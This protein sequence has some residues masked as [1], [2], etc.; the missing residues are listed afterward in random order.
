MQMQIEQAALDAASAGPHPPPADRLRAAAEYVIDRTRPDQ[1]ILF[2]SAARGEFDDRSDFDFAIVRAGASSG[3]SGIKHENWYCE[4][5]D[6]EIDALFIDLEQLEARRWT[7]GTVHCAILS[8]GLT[9]SPAAPPRRIDTLRDGGAEPADIRRLVEQG[10]YDTA[11][12]RELTERAREYL[13]S[14]I[15]IWNAAT[16]VQARF[17][18]IACE[19][20]GKAAL[21]AL[22]GLI[23][24][25][26]SPAVHGRDL[27]TLWMRAEEIGGMIN[28]QRNNRGLDEL[29]RYARETRESIGDAREA[30]AIFREARGT[31]E[32]LVQHA[33]KTAAA[34][35]G[36]DRR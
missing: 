16:P 6:A 30:G 15:T 25:N 11:W 28:G 27:T 22:K 12:A 13:D 21:Y 20:L 4:A 19:M 23:A 10:R 3:E 34:V 1:L 33:E 36:G 26:G 7:A 9:V 14:A 24:A 5:A 2:G 32:A 31:I 18:A 29:T 17:K 8:E 35:P